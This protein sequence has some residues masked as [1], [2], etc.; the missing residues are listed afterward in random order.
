[1]ALP[2][3]RV[4][5]F[6]P[7]A[8]RIFD[9]DRLGWLDRAAALGPVAAL[10]LGPFRAFVVTDPAT[11]REML[12]RDH[13]AWRRPPALVA[14]IRLGVG[15]NLFTQRDTDW[16]D[17]QPQ[18]VPCFRKANLA[19]RQRDLNALIHQEVGAL[20]RG[21][22]IDLEQAMGCLALRMAAWMLLGQ[23][24][25]HDQAQELGQHQRAVVQW[26]GARIGTLRAGLPIAFGTTRR[27][28][29]RHRQA[30]E[31]YADEVIR[32]HH[33]HDLGGPTVLSALLGARSAGRSLTPAELRAH[34]LGL[35]LAGNETT[36]A[37]LCW[38]LVEA[39][40]HPDAWCLVR[41]DP[42]QHAGSFINEVL[43]LHPPAWGLPR[44]PTRPGTSLASGTNQ[45]RVRRG[46]V[47][48]I[49]LRAIQRDPT[50]WTDP[51][52]FDPTRHHTD[53]ADT[54]WSLIPFGLG[55][56][57]CIGQHLAIAELHA[58][59]PQLAQ[60]GDPSIA[61]TAAEDANFSLRVRGGLTGHFAS[62]T[63]PS[64]T[65]GATHRQ[66]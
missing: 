28:A 55:P 51:L 24:L 34:V 1:M 19:A 38:T 23:H 2:E 14:P 64:P 48:T 22:A 65:D 58:A 16:A 5:R 53:R 29:R 13:E 10:R 43:R 57:G 49:Y 37:A 11:A 62:A 40:Q 54:L 45:I 61:D 32:A 41:D 39:A 8:L 6:L 50:V 66:A 42:T 3:L 44:T 15:E 9:A 60:H 47:A 56:R 26:V 7:A 31:A 18:L 12:V 36:A 52:R 4:H 59:V 17:L 21:I 30:L 27:A 20:P 35:L 46:Q 25:D 63:H 33:T